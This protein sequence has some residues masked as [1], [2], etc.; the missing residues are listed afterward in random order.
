MATT[1]AEILKRPY[2]RTVMPEP[3]GTFRSEI[4]EFPGCVAIGD[5]AVAALESLED[6][7]SSWLEAALSKNQPIPAPIE[8]TEG[9]SGKLMLRIPKSLH[10]KAAH[11]AA[12]DGVSLNQFILSSLSEQ[13]GVRTITARVRQQFAAVLGS[14][15]F[16]NVGVE[17]R[18]I[19]HLASPQELPLLTTGTQVVHYSGLHNA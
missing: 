8:G 14:S 19:P 13:I 15:R 2:A 1:P 6:V 16:F 12:R 3:D 7:A 10:K 5:T 18:S 9:F 4:I 17:T 11:I